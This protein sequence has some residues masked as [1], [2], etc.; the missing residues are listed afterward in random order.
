MSADKKAIITKVS[1]TRQIFSIIIVAGILFGIYIASTALMNLF[2]DERLPPSDELGEAEEENV[3]LMPVDIDI[4]AL[5]GLLDPELLEQYAQE[6][7]FYIGEYETFDDSWLWKFA[8]SDIYSTDGTWSQSTSG[9][10]PTSFTNQDEYN[11]SYSSRDML[12]IRMPLE[13]QSGI[14]SVTVPA[15]FPTPHIMNRPG[16]VPNTDNFSQ[17]SEPMT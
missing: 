9:E 10:S 7:V 12:R 15:L 8:V 4:M 2:F 13:A 6:V 11:A 1:Y 5:L 16:V 3:L 14:N 17:D